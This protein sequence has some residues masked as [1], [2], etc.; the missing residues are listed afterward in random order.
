MEYSGKKYQKQSQTEISKTLC[1]N[2]GIILIKELPF[3]LK[4]YNS[5]LTV[6]F[7]NMGYVMKA[8]ANTNY[9]LSKQNY[10]GI[11][12]S[13][14]KIG[15]ILLPPGII[16]MVPATLLEMLILTKPWI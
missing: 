1:N 8:C 3:I 2:I 11:Y 4:V 16:Y 13:I 10:S 9:N 6:L 12:T 14:R 7:K 15:K 5:Q